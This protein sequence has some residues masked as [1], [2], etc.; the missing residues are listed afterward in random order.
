MP[1]REINCDGILWVGDPHLSSLK[2]G[3]RKDKDFGKTVLG[4]IEQAYN[5]AEE[6]NLL[7]VFGG[8]LFDHPVESEERLKARLIR[9]IRRRESVCLGGNHDKS[10]EVL[11][12]DDSLGLIDSTGHLDVFNESGEIAVLNIGGRKVGL[13]GTGYGLPIPDDVTEIFDDV[14]KVL[15]LTHHDLAFGS[16][17]PGAAPLKEIKGCDLAINGHMHLTKKPK[18]VGDTMWVNPGNITR[19]AVDARD[20]EPAV[21]KWTPDMEQ[22]EKILLEYEKDIFDLT[23]Y[24]ADTLATATTVSPGETVSVEQK[25]NRESVFASLLAAEEAVEMARTEDASVLMEDIREKFVKDATP[26]PVQ[27]MILELVERSVG[28]PIVDRSTST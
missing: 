13:G 21:W 8:D 9:L 18:R 25:T 17:Y 16:S 15:W 14:E 20:H 27:N 28:K 26:V 6:H 4:K 24:H 10:Q 19:V 11:S 3:R 23:G 2:P 7:L 22:P 12:D 1:R 5:I